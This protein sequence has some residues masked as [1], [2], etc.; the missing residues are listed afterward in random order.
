MM[1]KY[2]NQKIKNKTLKLLKV[3]Q[4]CY[5]WL[6]DN[7]CPPFGPFIRRTV[8]Q[9][10]ILW[11]VCSPISAPTLGRPLCSLHSAAQTHIGEISEWSRWKG[12]QLLLQKSAMIFFRMSFTNIDEKSTLMWIG[13]TTYQA[14]QQTLWNKW[15]HFFLFIFVEGNKGENQRD[16]NVFYDKNVAS[17]EVIVACHWFFMHDFTKFS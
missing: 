8:F 13:G 7:K 6:Q 4:M 12:F 9:I 1:K 17:S 16:S 15:R 14:Q 3:R 10:Y 11:R 5:F 2:N